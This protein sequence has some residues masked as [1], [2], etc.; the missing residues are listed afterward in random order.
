MEVAL[1]VALLILLFIVSPLLMFVLLMRRL[2]RNNR[3][4]PSVPTLAPVSWTFLPE[5]PARLHRRLRRAISMA[6]VAAAGH[7]ARSGRSLATIPELV[8]DLEQR[9]CAVDS[10]LV[11]ASRSRGP[12]RWSLLN[13]IEHQVHEIDALASRVAGLASAWAASPVAGGSGPAALE[14]IGER[15]TALEMA[16]REVSAIGVNHPSVQ[17]AGG[18]AQPIPYLRRIQGERRD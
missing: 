4:S 11:V 13:D 16:M 18:P 14:A 8:A 6:R 17:P 1:V 7:V 9:A 15:V 3:I 12:L 10:E 2:A 5:R